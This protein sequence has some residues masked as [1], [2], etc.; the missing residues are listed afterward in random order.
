MDVKEY[1]KLSR[2]FKKRIEL[3]ADRSIS[4]SPEEV[5]KFVEEN[6]PKE[7]EIT[8]IVV[9]PAQSLIIIEAKNENFNQ[10]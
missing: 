1:R 10:K 9:Q 8:Q 3:R 6:I 5:K 4:K 2:D 7:A